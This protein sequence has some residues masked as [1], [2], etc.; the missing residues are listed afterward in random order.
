MT[1]RERV[2]ANL[3]FKQTDRIP[4]DLWVL[5]YVT[6]FE[7]DKIKEITKECPMDISGY[8]IGQLWNIWWEGTEKKGSYIDDWGSIWYV[9]EP[10]VA[11]EVKKP[12]LDSYFKL[13]SLKP[14]YHLIKTRDIYYINECCSKSSKFIL[15]DTAARPFVRLQF[16]RGTQNLFM[17]IGYDVP[18]FHKLL[19]MVHEFNLANIE[20]W[21]K[22][23]VDE[24]NFLD[25]WGTNK[26]LLINPKIFREIF[27]HLYKKSIA[28]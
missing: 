28:I 17:D 13:K 25:D 4:R 16:L 3:T 20:S 27:K 5:P 19:K 11:G 21:C 7:K 26:S 6:L 8:Q 14:P 24:I 2:K 18:E 23:E 15:S 9:G 12:F 22:T 1:G 10:G